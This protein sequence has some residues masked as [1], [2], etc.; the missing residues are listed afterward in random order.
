MANSQATAP[1][2]PQVLAQSAD[3]QVIKAHYG[4]AA[5][6]AHSITYVIPA[7]V[8]EVR[9]RNLDNSYRELAS[10]PERANDQFK[11]G[12]VD[13]QAQEKAFLDAVTQRSQADLGLIKMALELIKWYHGPVNRLAGGPFY[14]HPMAVA[15]I[16]LD[17]NTDEATILGALLHDTVEDTAILLQHLTLVFGKETAELVDVVTHLQRIEGSIYKV[18]L[19]AAENIKMLERIGNKRGLYVKLADRMHNMLTI[20]GHDDVNK[21]R[22]IAQETLDLFVPLARS[23]HLSEAADRLEAMC[24]EVLSAE[25][26]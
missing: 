7:N 16:V 21:R 3:E 2:T 19:S 11:H 25:A 6:S 12:K 9:P 1:D 22:L 13:A 14:L 4:H 18:K 15:Q 8:R 10:A 17:Y 20:K 5:V 24:H 23:L 26:P